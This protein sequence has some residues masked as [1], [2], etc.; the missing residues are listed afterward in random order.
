[1]TPREALKE[2][3]RSGQF[4]NTNS[5][6]QCVVERRGYVLV[7]CHWSPVR[8]NHCYDV[9]LRDERDKPLSGRETIDLS[10]TVHWMDL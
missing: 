2:A 6:G 9:I 10:K 5:F 4:K 8:G 1:M 7:Y 3:W